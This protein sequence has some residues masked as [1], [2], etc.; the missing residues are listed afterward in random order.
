[1]KDASRREID[2]QERKE[3]CEME[4]L[5]KDGLLEVKE[6]MRSQNK[7]REPEQWVETPIS[8]YLSFWE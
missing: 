6:E 1:M 5:W 8:H 4:E 2:Q 3:I 7:V